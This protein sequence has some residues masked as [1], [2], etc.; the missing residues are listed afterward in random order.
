MTTT[1]NTVI[2]ESIDLKDIARDGKDQIK[3]NKNSNNRESSNNK[4]SKLE[5]RS[6]LRI[7]LHNHDVSVLIGRGGANIKKL[8]EEQQ[9]I[10]QLPD[11]DSAERLLIIKGTINA[12]RSTLEAVFNLLSRDHRNDHGEVEC[13]FL[14]HQSHAGP[15]I[16]HNGEHVK[17]LRNR[18]ELDIKVFSRRC[19]LST[20]RVVLLK[21]PVSQVI[22]CIDDTLQLT[23]LHPIKGVIQPYDPYNADE[24]FADDYGGFVSASDR[25]GSRFGGGSGV[26]RGGRSHSYRS[27][28]QSA[29][30]LMH[31]LP[32]PWGLQSPLMGGE[33]S[34]KRRRLISPDRNYTMRNNDGLFDD[35]SP[36]MDMLRRLNHFSS[37]LSSGSM[38]DN[39]RDMRRGRARSPL[40]SKHYDRHRGFSRSRNDRY[41]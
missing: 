20:D 40:S 4:D 18:F 15:F 35:R 5:Q 34:A 14:I 37:S 21:G 28:R 7:M 38:Y 3:N 23:H 16:G 22:D 6:E 41:A 11:S 36:R 1:T 24:F 9:T 13:R 10:I 19:P 29:D 27:N 26:G 8:R 31:M 33:T 32:H 2:E 12:C 30:A 39:G 17:E 25:R